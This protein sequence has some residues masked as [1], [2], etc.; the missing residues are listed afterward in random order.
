MTLSSLCDAIIKYSLYAALFLTPVFFLPLTPYPASLNRQFVFTA[1][2]GVAMGAWI[3]KSVRA[4]KIE[5]P[6]GLASASLAALALFVAVSAL[7]SGASAIGFM[8]LSAGEPDTAIAIL[9]FAFL[10]FLLAV[11]AKDKDYD[12]RALMALAAS[13]ALAVIAALPAMLAALTAFI[14]YPF[15]T[16][17]FVTVNTVGT[18]NAFGLYAGFIGILTF[19]M[20]RHAGVS[21]RLRPWLTALAAISSALVLLIGY[22]AIF[23]AIALALAVFALFDGRVRRLAYAGIAV[24]ACMVVIGA[25]FISLPLPRIAAAPEVAPSVSASL[26]IA[27]ATAGEGVKNFLLGSGPAT[28]AYQ[29]ARYRD[30]GLNATPFWGVRFTQGFNAILTHLVSWGIFGTL[31]LVAFIIFSAYAAFR[32]VRKPKPGGVTVI[33]TA[34]FAYTGVA[35]FLYPQNFVLYFLLFAVAGLIAGR[36]MEA[37]GAQG[38]L[39]MHPWVGVFACGAVL[40]LMFVNGKRYVAAIEFARGINAVEETKDVSRA[41]PLIARGS[42]LDSKN[43]AYLQALASAYLAQANAIA[44]A[45]G[46]NADEEVKKQVAETVALAVSAAERSTQVNPANAENWVGLGQV[47]D[48]IAPFNEGAAA[49]AIAVYGKARSLDPANPV[50]PTY[51]G[52]SRRAAAERMK[53]GAAPEYAAAQAAYEEAIALKQ[54]YAPAHFGLIGMFDVLGKGADAAARAERLRA[55]VPDNAEI[56]F[57]L[58]VI[59]YQAGRTAL[60]RTA[61]ERAV[62]IA[63]NY[64]NALYFLGL[65]H[66]KDGDAVRAIE[67]LERVLQLNPDSAEVKEALAGLRA[68]K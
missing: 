31:L 59:H 49:S 37:R 45:A 68:K 15:A 14:G 64:A 26:R 41:L 48:A 34:L 4:K 56:L 1:L 2:V 42:G 62:A 29:Y 18:T 10:Y 63:P 33:M 16:W 7:F 51:I 25:G 39:S 60:A 40:A 22:W 57:Q 61:L 67:Y 5:Y 52:G 53:S 9:S 17:D 43:D 13:G 66:A 35:L 44:A 20:L 11:S 12:A 54:D 32:L 28:Y 23:V 36:G 30:A 47:Y 3:V 38:S 58:G 65:A 50:I 27:R 6:K 46:A 21:P 8:G 19:G 55:I 24:C